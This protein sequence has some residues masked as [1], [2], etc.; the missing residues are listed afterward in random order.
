MKAVKLNFPA[1]EYHTANGLSKSGMTKLLKSPAHYKAFLNEEK[2][3]TKAMQIGTATH[4]AILEPHIY[5]STVAIRPVGLDGR[6]KEGKQWAVENEGKIQLTQEEAQDIQGMAKAVFDHQIYKSEIQGRSQKIEAS[7]FEELE[8]G[9]VLKARPD[10]WIE[11]TLFDIKTTEDASEGSFTKT[12][13]NLMY[14]LQAAHYL[15]MADAQRF[16]FIAVERHAPYAV[17]VFELDPAWITLGNTL[18]EKAIQILHECQVLDH[19]PAYNANLK[20]LAMPKWI[21]SQTEI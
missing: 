8:S 7:I 4:T 14:H 9:V 20:T 2:Q 10:L 19:W 5:N 12:C 15:K 18:R 1:Q 6:T 11:G 17:N 16:V 3:A 21:A 13:A